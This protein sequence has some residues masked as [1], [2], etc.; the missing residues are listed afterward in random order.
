MDQGPGPDQAP[1]AEARAQ[2][3]SS[4][5]R[6]LLAIG[7][8]A[9][10]A[11]VAVVVIALAAGGSDDSEAG[12]VEPS[13]SESA[14]SAETSV[15]EPTDTSG[16]SADDTEASGPQATGVD[17]VT[18]STS[19]TTPAESSTEPATDGDTAS[20]EQ[21]P[22]SL[23]TVPEGELEV[24]DPID[25][26]E[27]AEVAGGGVTVS[28]VGIE[29]VD[30]E[31]TEQFQIAGPALRV[32]L[33]VTNDTDEPFSLEG[34]QVEVFYGDDLVP[35]ILLGGPDV[36]PFPSSVGPGATAIGAVVYNV[37]P[38]QRHHIQVVVF[39]GVDE[40]VIIF[41]GEGPAA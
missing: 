35:G 19:T 38:D 32:E 20:Q 21:P 30:G 16:D 11:V 4:R 26:D 39:I 17:P 40:P 24:D 7:A 22:A 41:E 27:T 18:E 13:A 5:R 2:H 8:A 15:T 33:Q 3:G 29:A 37:P 14:T 36:V 23:V 28:I 6:R 9:T 31:A 12:S 34:I 10:I 25:I 1:G